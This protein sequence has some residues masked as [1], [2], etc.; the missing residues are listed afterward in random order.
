MA[1]ILIGYTK[2]PKCG[3]IISDLVD[4]ELAAFPPDPALPNG[5]ADAVMCLSCVPSEF[6]YAAYLTQYINKMNYD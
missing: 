3:A 2:C 1:L 5:L 4:E 6:D